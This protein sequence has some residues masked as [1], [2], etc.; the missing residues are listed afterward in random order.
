MKSWTKPKM[1]NITLHARVVCHYGALVMEFL[2]SWDLGN[3]E[4]DFS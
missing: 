4:C 1:P 2:D 3:G